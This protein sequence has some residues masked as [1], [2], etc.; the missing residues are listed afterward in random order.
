[1]SMSTL[2][3]SAPEVL[4]T[5]LDPKVGEA[6]GDEILLASVRAEKVEKVPATGRGSSLQSHSARAWTMGGQVD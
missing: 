6:L 3:T 5:T 2:T 1:M 4:P